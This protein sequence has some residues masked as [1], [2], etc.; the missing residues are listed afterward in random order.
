MYDLKLFVGYNINF[1]EAFHVVIAIT[2]III[3]WVW[4]WSVESVLGVVGFAG[5]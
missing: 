5:L 2:V 4:Q 3:V 1:D